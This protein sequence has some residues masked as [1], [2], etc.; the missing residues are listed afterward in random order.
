V[1]GWSTRALEHLQRGAVMDTAQEERNILYKGAREAAAEEYMQ[2][3]PQYREMSN[4]MAELKLIVRATS[5]LLAIDI[6]D[7]FQPP[8]DVFK[9]GDNRPVRKSVKGSVT[10]P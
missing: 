8:V 3:L 9:P 10:G 1:L 4:R 7:E 5:R 6:P 2:L